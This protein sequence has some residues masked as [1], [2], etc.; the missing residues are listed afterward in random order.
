MKHFIGF[1]CFVAVLHFFL[2]FSLPLRAQSPGVR[3][4][5]T[6]MRLWPDNGDSST[7]RWTYDEAVVWKGLEGLWYN[8]GD[9]QYFRYVQHQVDRLVDKEGNIRNFKSGK[10]KL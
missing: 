4:A 3:L 7:A 5:A 1:V 8:T 10:I 2:V 9:A 6:A